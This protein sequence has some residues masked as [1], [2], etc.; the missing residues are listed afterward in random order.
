[1]KKSSLVL[2]VL[3]LMLGLAPALAQMVQGALAQSQGE[4]CKQATRVVYEQVFMGKLEL[5]DQIYAPNSKHHDPGVP[6][7]EW[8]QGPAIAKAVVGVYLTAFPDLN[9]KI[10]N[11][12][13]D[14]DTAITQWVS[15]GTHKG[16]LMG[17]PATGKSGSMAGIVI[18]RCEGGKV[19]EDWT[20]YDLFGLFVQLGLITPPAP[21]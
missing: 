19:V 15:S 6:G 4:I 5:A 3:G 14:G 20:V 10:L 8:P 12:Y 1:M 7:G 13:V 9:I 2:S 18:A 17:I 21:K 16:P 11:Q